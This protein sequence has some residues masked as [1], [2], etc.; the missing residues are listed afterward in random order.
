MTNENTLPACWRDVHDALQAGQDRLVLFGPPG[1][2]KTKAG[3]TFGV[4][5]GQEALR[6]IC[7]QEMTDSDFR[8]HYMPTENGSWQF[9]EGVAIRAWRTG[10]R[11]VADEVD[12]LSGDVESIALAM[13]DSVESASW[14]NPATGEVVTPQPGFSVV[15]TTNIEDRRDL[16][17][18]LVDRFPVM[19]RINTP[20]PDALVRLSEDLRV[21]AAN[22]ADADSD[23]RI[24]LRTWLAFDNMRK[25]FRISMNDDALAQ[26]RAA[27]IIFQ[28][29][30]RDILDSLEINSIS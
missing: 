8:G 5:P 29:R 22:S 4:L 30:T 2:G 3:L 15:M 24:S 16:P 20:H 10:G 17:M 21:A 23:R 1:T 14:T 7:N 13:F 19:I 27:Q 6:L 12:R 26:E 28:D 9:K 25:Q 11:L 18:A